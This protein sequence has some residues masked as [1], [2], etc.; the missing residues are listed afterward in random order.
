MP[1]DTI[2]KTGDIVEI[3]TSEKSGGP[4]RD[5]IKKVKTPMARTRIIRWFKKKNREES[6]EKGKSILEEDII[7]ISLKPGD[8]LNK[9]YLTAVLEKMNIATEDDLY[10]LIGFGTLSHKKVLTRLLEEYEKDFGNFNFEQ[11][12]KKLE[13][14]LNKTNNEANTDNKVFVEGYDN[15]LTTIAKCCVPLP[16]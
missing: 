16:R 10:G 4:S 8:L 2:L 14:N 15:F 6:I 13:E 1:I 5:W 12:I 11:K 3:L 9:K 7:K